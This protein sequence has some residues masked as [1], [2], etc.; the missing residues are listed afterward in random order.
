[1]IT[2]FFSHIC[3]CCVTAFLDQSIFTI[4]SDFEPDGDKKSR[5]FGGFVVE[6]GYQAKRWNA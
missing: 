3:V 1:M 5:F 4:S 2:N 6:R